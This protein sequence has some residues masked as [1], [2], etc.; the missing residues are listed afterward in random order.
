M[1]HIFI[2]FISLF[3]IALLLVV[4]HAALMSVHALNVWLERHSW[5]QI[6]TQVSNLQK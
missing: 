4:H 6:V 5:V 3:Q 2:I 1:Y